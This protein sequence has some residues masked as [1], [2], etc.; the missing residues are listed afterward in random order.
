MNKIINSSIW[1]FK[2]IFKNLCI[3]IMCIR[4]L[5][6]SV[7]CL[8]WIVVNN[9]IIVWNHFAFEEAVF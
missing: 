3:L 7:W 9:R 1:D 2:N 8:E 5:V 4:F 6:N